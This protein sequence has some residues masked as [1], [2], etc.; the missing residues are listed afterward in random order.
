MMSVNT[1]YLRITNVTFILLLG[2]YSA[3]GTYPLLNTIGTDN[4]PDNEKILFYDMKTNYSIAIAINA[5]ETEKW[6]ALEL[7]HWLMDISNAYFPIIEYTQEKIGMGDELNPKIFV[8]YSAAMK[9]VMNKPEPEYGDES[10]Q[11]FNVGADLYIYGGKLRGTM[12]GV[13][14]FLENEF[15]CRWYTPVVKV[16]PPKRAYR[17][18]SLDHSESPGIDVRNDFYYLAFDPVWAARNKINGRHSGGTSVQVQPGGVESYWRVH[19]FY[20]FMPSEE[21]FDDHPEYYSLI[22]GKRIADQ[23]ESWSERGQLCLSHPE[24]LKIITERV[25]KQMREHPGHMIYSV[26]QNDW[27]NPCQCDKCQAIVNK[28]GGEESGIIVWFVNKV[29]Q[30]IEQE[31]PDKYIGTLAYQYTRSAP[32]DI[33]PRNN[34]VIRLCPIEACVAH[35]LEKCPKNESFMKDMKAWSDISPQLFIW[36]YVVNFARYIMPYPNFKVLQPNIQTFQHNKAIGIMEQGA[37]QDRGGEF[38]ELKAYIIAK[39]LWDPYCDVESVIDDFMAGFY[40]RAG[41]FIREYF[42]LLQNQITPETHMFIGLKQDDPI[43][44]DDFVKRSMEIL[45]NAHRVADDDEISR[46]VEMATLPILFL[47]CKRSPEVARVDGTFQK[48]LS[49]IEKEGITMISEYG[50]NLDAF[51][52]FVMKTN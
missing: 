24:V 35:A 31:F 6:A 14:A 37:Y 13:M 28:F 48:L 11:Y 45:Y 29:A 4:E 26:S 8:G 44:S 2:F 18:Y 40:G 7:Q 10:F 43:F 34:V 25:R 49:I 22:D 9:E 12:Y 41:T 50:E 16:I 46:R 17:F 21:F 33:K 30:A 27:R 15:G 32:H 42:D 38:S 1:N 19:T 51:K 3:W 20:Y 5:S 36:D 23:A 39:L 52:E 47:K